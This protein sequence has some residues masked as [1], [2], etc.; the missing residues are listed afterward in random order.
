VSPTVKTLRSERVF[1]GVLPASVSSLI[2]FSLHHG[3]WLR[4]GSSPLI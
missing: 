2:A 1:N 3:R 4:S